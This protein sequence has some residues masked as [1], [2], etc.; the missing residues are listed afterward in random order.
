MVNMPHPALIVVDMQEHFRD[1]MAETIVENVNNLV[2]ECLQNSIPITFTQH[3]HLDRDFEKPPK[4]A[5]VLVKW[6][7]AS[8]SIRSVYLVCG[9]NYGAYMEY[10]GRRVLKTRP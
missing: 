5:N 2:G 1:G 8:N 3:G 4:P 7:G 9:D 10:F 6:W